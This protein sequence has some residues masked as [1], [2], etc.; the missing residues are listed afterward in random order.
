MVR[1]EELVVRA[2]GR[3]GENLQELSASLR[4]LMSMLSRI[5][6]QRDGAVRRQDRAS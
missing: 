6:K 5:L 1:F 2:E 3:D 4:M